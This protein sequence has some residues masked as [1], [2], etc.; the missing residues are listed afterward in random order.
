MTFQLSDDDG[1]NDDVTVHPDDAYA[2]GQ[3]EQLRESHGADTAE[4]RQGPAGRRV[5]YSS[6]EVQAL[7]EGFAY[8]F[9]QLLFARASATRTGLSDKEM[10]VRLLDLE[11]ALS[12]LPADEYEAVEWHALKMLTFDEA[13]RHLKGSRS[14][15]HD[16]YTRALKRVVTQL[17]TASSYSPRPGRRL[18]WQTWIMQDVSMEL[19][20]PI[21]RDGGRPRERGRPPRIARELEDRIIG[22]YESGLTLRQV[23]EA[24]NQEQLPAP[25]GGVWRA[26]SFRT[27]FKRRGVKVRAPGRQPKPGTY[28]LGDLSRRIS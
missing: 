7:L 3:V 10:H 16:L 21:A 24:L 23:A 2:V 11:R 20:E 27:L 22:M 15:L 18:F 1:S 5:H 19:A 6:A 14:S 25:G 12:Y 17:N 9:A 4:D 28:T 26:T 13:A 8:F